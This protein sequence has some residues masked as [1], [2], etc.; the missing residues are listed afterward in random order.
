MRE[1]IEALGGQ[2]GYVHLHDNRGDEDE[3]LGLGSGTIPMR[4]VCAALERQSPEAIWAMEIK[5]PYLE[6]SVDWLGSVG[7]K[8]SS[9][10]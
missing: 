4:E 5:V 8:K 2:I 7:S 9:R 6:E 1:W 10:S 3:H